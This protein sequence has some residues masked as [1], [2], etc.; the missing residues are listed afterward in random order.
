VTSGL[1]KGDWSS[2]ASLSPIEKIQV[3][4][5][6]FHLLS[7]L[8]RTGGIREAREVAEGLRPAGAVYGFLARNQG[9]TI[10][11]ILP[12]ALKY[13]V[14]AFRGRSGAGQ[15]AEVAAPGFLEE[16]LRRP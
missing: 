12:I 6:G 14:G 5:L 7:E 8:R 9:S 2:A 10:E 4:A 15:D 11:A 3:E 13:D 1:W 16:P